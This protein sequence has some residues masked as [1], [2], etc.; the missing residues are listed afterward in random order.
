ML[1]ISTDILVMTTIIKSLT[2]PTEVITINKKDCDRLMRKIKMQRYH[3]WGLIEKLA[4]NTYTDQYNT[5]A[6]IFLTYSRSYASSV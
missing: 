3:K 5:S 6:L 1:K 4:T 2:Y